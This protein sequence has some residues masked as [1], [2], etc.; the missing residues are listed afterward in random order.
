M[1]KKWQLVPFFFFFP[2]R[3]IIR[4]KISTVIGI[5]LLLWHATHKTRKWSWLHGVKSKFLKN[6]LKIYYQ[7]FSIYKFITKNRNF[8][9]C[10]NYI[11]SIIIYFPKYGEYY[12]KFVE[13]IPLVYF[14]LVFHMNITKFLLWVIHPCVTEQHIIQSN[15]RVLTENPFW[16]KQLTF[17]C[18]KSWNI[19]IHGQWVNGSSN[20]LT[21]ICM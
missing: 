3:G 13:I 17:K 10:T 12:Q 18:H 1:W 11:S 15:K 6:P 8:K 7:V 5:A 2:C 9:I 14:W 20:P 19:P 4:K 16:I 21:I